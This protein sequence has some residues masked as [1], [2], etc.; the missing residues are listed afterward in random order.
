MNVLETDRLPSTATSPGRAAPS[1]RRERPISATHCV[2]IITAVDGDQFT[3]ASGTL[4]GPGRRAVSC[5][6]EPTIGDTVAALIVAPDQL[7]ITA[8]LQ[9]EEGTSH[10]LRLNGPTCIDTG[11][12][13]L[14][15][16]SGSLG[17]KTAAFVLN[18]QRAELHSDEAIVMGREF[19]VIGNTM[20]LVGAVLNTVFDRVM[21][22]SKQHSRRTEGMDRVS[23]DY[24]EVQAKQILR[25]T[26]EHVFVNGE[27]MVKTT[28][29]QIHFG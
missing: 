6:L 7:W 9:R 11:E 18:T 13:A 28:G 4:T 1:T 10:T 15:V 25:Q 22:Y 17:F 3:I 14:T 19:K 21:H 27:K 8:V 12:A 5:L 23:G 26:G 2:G 24:V 29:S 20:K 16:A